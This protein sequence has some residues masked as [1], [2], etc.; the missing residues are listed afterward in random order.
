MSQNA[1]RFTGDG[2]G[3]SSLLLNLHFQSLMSE[4]LQNEMSYNTVHKA[5]WETWE[6]KLMLSLIHAAPIPPSQ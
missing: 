2:G 5:F 1:D 3:G 4:C 6:A